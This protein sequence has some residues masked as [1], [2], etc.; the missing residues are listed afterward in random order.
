MQLGL[1]RRTNGVNRPYAAHEPIRVSKDR[2]RERGPQP[3]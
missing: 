1:N 2:E 3:L